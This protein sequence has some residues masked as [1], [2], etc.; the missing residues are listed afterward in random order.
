MRRVG[1]AGTLDP[2]ADGVL[3]V[4]FGRATRVV[5]YLMDAR[6]VYLVSIHLGIETDTYDADG[7]T[8]AE[9]DASHI[10][11]AQIEAAL[12]QFRGEIMQRPPHFSAIKKEGVPL[13]KHA[14]AGRILEVPARPVFIYRLDIRSYEPPCLVLE[15]ECG[16]GTY[17]RSLAH[18]LGAG[19]GVGAMVAALTRTRVG[20]FPIDNAVDLET[21]SLEVEERRWQER[22][23][24]LDEVV[25][26]WPAAILGPENERL[27]LTGRAPALALRPGYR[28]QA[29][30]RCRAY[31]PGGDFLAVLRA[32]P[33]AEWLPEK[34]FA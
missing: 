31:G 24:P 20:P 14:R 26:D 17:V 8:I 16:K 23:L 30:E 27:L 33:L 1:H 28:L 11:L 32:G 22:L 2:L 10:S 34:V 18:D 5:E 3:P 29:G 25:L 6:K 21:L 12:L 4:C 19:L 7:Q 15:V 9:K 13:Y